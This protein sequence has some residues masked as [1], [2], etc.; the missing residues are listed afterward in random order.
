MDAEIGKN[1]ETALRQQIEAFKPSLGIE[2]VG[3]VLEVGDG[4]ARVKGLASVKSQELVE[5]ANGTWGMALNLE[6]NQVGV[7][8]MGEYADIPEGSHVRAIGRVASV[9]VGEGLLGRVINPLGEPLDGQG[10]L[11]YESLREVERL[12]PG[13]IER[14]D[15]HRPIQTGIKAIDAMFPIGRGQRQLI[16]GD[17]QTGKTAIV[18]DT[19]IN[20]NGE[21]VICIYVAIGQ[22]R[23]QVARVVATLEQYGALGHTVIINASASD[24]A[25]LQYLAPY[26]GCAIGEYFMENGRHAL[27]VYD[28]LTKHAWAYCF[29]ARRA[30]KPIRA[31]SFICT[32]ACLNALPS[33]RTSGVGGA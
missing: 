12:A 33:F 24:S 25:A 6:E 14:Q 19:I 26:A 11:D 30:V 2:N 27:V 3:T 13:V 23:A 20:Q 4:I 18:I 32:P 16:I 15:V 9:P 5:F 22:K 7:I 8:V 29:D 31:I 21:D 28:D 10:A 1:L 17:R